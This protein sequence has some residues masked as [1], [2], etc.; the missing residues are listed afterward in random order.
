M[1]STDMRK[2]CPTATR[3]PAYRSCRPAR[4]WSSP[5]T[6]SVV[7]VHGLTPP[8]PDLSPNPFPGRE[9]ETLFLSGAPPLRPRSPQ[10]RGNASPLRP[11][12]DHTRFDTGTAHALLPHFAQYG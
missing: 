7:L 5:T 11:R 12:V 3:R 10:G 2:R 1:R 4:P 8:R 6:R 9:G